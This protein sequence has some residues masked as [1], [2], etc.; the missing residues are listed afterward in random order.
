MT[1]P[2]NRWVD[3]G[4]KL[5]IMEVYVYSEA[6]EALGFNPKD[7]PDRADMVAEWIQW[8]MNIMAYE[9]GGNMLDDHGKLTTVEVVQGGIPG[10]VDVANPDKWSVIIQNHDD[11]GISHTRID[12]SW[13]EIENALFAAKVLH[14]ERGYATT[15][16]VMSHGE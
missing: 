4:I 15:Y 13:D 7:Y 1:Q 2:D 5:S 11:G 9:N 10:F 8:H 14:E 12:G 3:L 6:A 16:E